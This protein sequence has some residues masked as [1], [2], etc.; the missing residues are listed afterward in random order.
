M[1]TE[2]VRGLG[3]RAK[4]G[5][6]KL[7]GQF[8]PL[9]A[10]V[11]A[12][13]KLPYSHLILRPKPALGSSAITAREK[14]MPVDSM[15]EQVS[16]DADGRF[17]KGRSGNPNGRPMG[18]RNKATEAAELLLDGEAEALTR[19]AVELALEGEG[20]A[21][22]LCLERIIPPRRER[23]VKLGLPAVRGAADLAGTMAA[24]TTAA[25]QGTITPGQAAE[26]ARVV[27]IFVRAV[28]TSDFERRLR[29]LEE[30]YAARP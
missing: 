1:P 20:S 22:R 6:T 23:P 15:Q 29:E 27:E 4:L 3:P 13:L 14:S 30:A 19:K 5:Q 24:I 8:R 2:P 11:T 12:T 16:R 21:L 10:A 26:L 28:E 9:V 25:T 18:T 7:A 17:R